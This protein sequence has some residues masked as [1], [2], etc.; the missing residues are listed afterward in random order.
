MNFYFLENKLLMQSLI[1]QTFID[2]LSWVGPYA[3]M[4]NVKEKKTPA[5]K[6]HGTHIWPERLVRSM[7]GP[8]LIFLLQLKSLP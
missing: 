3:R 6:F 7:S 8:I 2:D 1:Q 4:L 5:T